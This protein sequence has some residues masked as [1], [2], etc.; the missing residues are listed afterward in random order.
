MHTNVAKTVVSEIEPP[1]PCRDVAI[2]RS[3]DVNDFYEMLSEIGRGK[4]GT[5]YLCR[6]KSTGLELAAKLVSVSRRDE[7][8]NVERE[9]D[10]H[11]ERSPAPPGAK[12]I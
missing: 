8:R 10:H 9:V 12:A 6:E 5:V 7:R 1:F 3:T 11:F 4:F 2:K